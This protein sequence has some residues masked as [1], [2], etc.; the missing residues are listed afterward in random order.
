MVSIF[1]P[2]A[3]NPEGHNVVVLAVCFL[4]VTWPILGLRFWVRHFLLHLLGIDDVLALLAQIGFTGY[5][6]S[7]MVTIHFTPGA[8]PDSI[9]IGEKTAAAFTASTTTYAAGM[10]F[11]KLSL[12][13]FFLR[14]LVTPLQR[15]T[16]Y[17]MMVISSISNLME[18]IW[19][20]FLCGVPDGQAY[21]RILEKKCATVPTQ[22]GIAYSQAA[23]N[24]VTDIG[25]ALMPVWLLWSMQMKASTKISVGAILL[26]ATGGCIASMVRIKYVGLILD[27]T[28][29]FFRTVTPLMMMC[30]IELGAGLL[31]CS[32]ATLRP[33]LALWLGVTASSKYSNKP[34]YTSSQSGGDGAAKSRL[35]SKSSEYV[36]PKLSRHAE[37]VEKGRDKEFMNFQIRGLSFSGTRGSKTRGGRSEDSDANLV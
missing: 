3:D 31:A 20:I 35:S 13:A 7:L 23:V 29:G 5:C 10:L 8:D 26:L 32:L 33:L 25:L 27:P 11:L 30:I 37:D 28:F 36:L 12:G 18:G 2:N 1:T 17:F 6:V 16:V 24:T 9:P 21:L 19:V 15:N 34:N 4:A 22:A 14:I